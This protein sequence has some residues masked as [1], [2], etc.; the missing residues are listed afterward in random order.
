MTKRQI[1]LNNT[2]DIKQKIANALGN[3]V[4]VVLNSG[5]V[6]FGEALEL[7]GEELIIKNMRLKLMSFLLSDIN[8]VIIDTN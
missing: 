1:R 7:K 4:N 8:E 5:V 6:F 2:A 3:K